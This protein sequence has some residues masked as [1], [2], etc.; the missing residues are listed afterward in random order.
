M[1]R[2]LG[3]RWER[4]PGDVA[5]RA[6]VEDLR[7]GLSAGIVVDAD[8]LALF[9]ENGQVREVVG[10]GSYTLETLLDRLRFWRPGRALEVA[11]V[12][13]GPHPASFTFEEVV[14]KDEQ[15]ARL[16][17]D[18]ELAV[19][20]AAGLATALLPGPAEV[21]VAALCARIRPALRL[22]VEAVVGQ[23]PVLEG[24]RRER[25]AT[26]LEAEFG[27]ALAR[28][29]LALVGLGGLRLSAEGA[30]RL[31]A[32]RGED[33]MLSAE[34][35]RLGRRA[36]ALARLREVLRGDRVDALRDERGLERLLGEI[37]RE[38]LLDGRDRERILRAFAEED[39]GR[40]RALDLVEDEHQRARRAA[41]A[42]FARSE[43]LQGVHA[44]IERQTRAHRAEQELR[45][46]EHH[47]DVEEA[48]D[49]IELLREMK[50]AK[51]ESRLEEESGH[52]DLEERRRG[53]DDAERERTQQRELDRLRVLDALGADTKVLAASDG[54]RA[55]V[56][57]QMAR[58]ERAGSLSPEQ[59]L[60]LVADRSPEAAT[61]LARGGA[62]SAD[63]LRQLYER[64]LSV[65]ADAYQG[66]QGAMRELAGQA[67]ATQ[68]AVA[69]EASRRVP[70]RRG[71][72]APRRAERCPDDAH[73]ASP[74][75]HFCPRCGTA[76]R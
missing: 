14:T 43:E 65:T 72:A 19:T 69:R 16:A 62:A 11:L 15:L 10:P 39:R 22:A 53:L 13:R 74:E 18:M 9:F 70:E 38:R 17:C 42:A 49:G 60:A 54:E 27:A 57:E 1:G 75:D 6:R 37:D 32:E 4:Q 31:R 20:S 44:T 55:R 47:R 23:E 45:A 25:I 46:A 35:D 52:L 3:R 50:R 2:L 61:A 71:E 24:P 51:R 7:E 58:G 73:A 63:E 33:A 68:A 5:I 36:E 67:M 21:G 76:L 29:G 41:E 34:A 12:A 66:S 28:F 40:E 48:R 64:M 26:A 56:L 59:L 8:V 30:S